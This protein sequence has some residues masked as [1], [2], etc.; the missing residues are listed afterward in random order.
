M[1]TTEKCRCGDP[2]VKK[3]TVYRL[4]WSPK[5]KRPPKKKVEQRWMCMRH[6]LE[7][8]FGLWPYTCTRACEKV[9]RKASDCAQLNETD[10]LTWIP[11]DMM[12]ST[13]TMRPS[14]PWCH[15]MLRPYPRPSRP[16]RV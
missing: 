9:R 1:K 8:E 16:R 10:F 3:G 2:G 5:G 7:G 13:R 4:Q 6:Y 11:L 14:C 12:A 15:R